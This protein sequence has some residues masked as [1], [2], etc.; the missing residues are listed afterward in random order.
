LLGKYITF[1]QSQ[2]RGRVQLFRY[3]ITVGGAILLNYLFIKLFVEYFHLFPTVSK[4]LTTVFVVAY[5][6]VVQKY[7]TFRIAATKG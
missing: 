6:Y 7:Y 4:M 2:L 5:S 3:G 1:S